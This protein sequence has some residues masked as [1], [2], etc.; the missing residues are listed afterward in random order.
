[1]PFPENTPTPDD[2]PELDPKE[3]AD[4]PVEMLAVLQHE[5]DARLRRDK[6]AK[7][8]LDGALSV[9]YADRA[10][11]ERRAAAKDTGTVRFHDGDFTVVADL[12]KRV[13]WDQAQLAAMVER[14]RAAGAGVMGF[15]TNIG[16]DTVLA[17]GKQR[18]ETATGEG[19]FEPALHADFALV[20]ADC[21]DRFGN[22]SFAASARNFNPLIA[23]AARC[24]IA[25]AERVVP[26]GGIAPDDVHTPGPFVDHVVEL[27]TL[28]E[29]YG[30]VQR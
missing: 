28:P 10:I 8:R 12:P 29:V 2:L 3:I 25:E 26:L 1:M 4:L 14:I 9:R 18:V 15:V 21:A 13:D 27:P 16:M 23:T 22:L 30:V 24:V 6:A 17:A 11:E 7:A 19:M 20:H 5:I